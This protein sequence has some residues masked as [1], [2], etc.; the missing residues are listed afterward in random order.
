MTTTEAPAGILAS[1]A[2]QLTEMQAEQGPRTAEQ[3]DREADLW[4]SVVAA[5]IDDHE[6]RHD[7]ARLLIYAGIA[8]QLA[9]MDG[10]RELHRK[11]AGHLA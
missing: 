8:A 10:A 11:A 2:A 3:L 5:T 1:L 4:R 9:A 6:V 7:V